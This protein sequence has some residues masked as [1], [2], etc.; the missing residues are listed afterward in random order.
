M[1]SSIGN[2][3]NNILALEKGQDLAVPDCLDDML[4]RADL[5]QSKPITTYK[6]PDYNPTGSEPGG[7]SEPT[8]Y[9]QEGIEI[10]CSVTLKDGQ[11]IQPDGKEKGY[12][13]YLLKDGSLAVFSYERDYSAKNSP[14]TWYPSSADSTAIFSAKLENLVPKENLITKVCI[15][16]TE[17]DIIYSSND[18]SHCFYIIRAR[19]EP[20]DG[21]H[22]EENHEFFR[23]DREYLMKGMEAALASDDEKATVIFKGQ[24]AYNG[25]ARDGSQKPAE[26]KKRDATIYL[27]I[28]A[29]RVI[30]KCAAGEVTV[31]YLMKK[32]QENNLVRVLKPADG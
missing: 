8:F 24:Y 5:E 20:R 28:D 16:P 2:V 29:S 13:L 18:P 26:P 4:R 1:Q 31:Y 9:E 22:P 10:A 11:R 25:C 17:S 15:G 3:I 14:G 21:S 19:S 32:L 27:Q 12:I 23:F 30:P 6:D 7:L